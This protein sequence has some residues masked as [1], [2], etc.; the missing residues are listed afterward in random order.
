MTISRQDIDA[1]IEL[2]C[3]RFP[4]AFFRFER[5]RVPLKLG[6]RDDLIAA[7]GDT[8]DPELIGLALKGY[9]AYRRSQL[10]GAARIDLEG[11]PA[12]TVSEADALSAAK[13]V[14]LRIA[15]LR[16]RQSL[17]K[18]QAKASPAP[19]PETPAPP[20]PPPP[21]PP[22]KDGLT[23]SVKPQSGGGKQRPTIKTALMRLARARY[24]LPGEPDTLNRETGWPCSHG[25]NIGSK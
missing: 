6:I 21:P 9:M 3:E 18:T 12:G 7:L 4:R 13:D 16:E 1:T 24:E 8:I 23:R 2:L 25:S 17:A 19:A 14:I 15:A 22:R 10:Q 5:M 20:P 11:E